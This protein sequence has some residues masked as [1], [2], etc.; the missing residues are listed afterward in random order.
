MKSFFKKL[1]IVLALFFTSS[2]INATVHTVNNG[3][4]TGGH[5]TDLQTAID[6]ANVG[7]TLYV[8]GSPNSYGA[9][10]LNKRLTLIGSGYN[11]TGTPNNFSTLVSSLTVDS[12]L[13]FS[14]ATG[15]KIIG[16]DIQNLSY[17]YISG[18]GSYFTSNLYISRCKIGSLYVFENSVLENSIITS[19][20]YLSA[21]SAIIRNNIIAS[22]SGQVSNSSGVIFDHNI[23]NG[24][25]PS[26]LSYALFSNNVFFFSGSTSN[27]SSINNCV[28]N[29]NLSSDNV[30][31]TLP[32]GTNSGSGNISTVMPSFQFNNTLTASSTSPWQNNWTLKPTSGGKNAAT[33]GTDIGIYGGN[34]PMKNL[35][36]VSNLIPQMTLMNINNSSIPLNGTLNVNF[37][38]RKQN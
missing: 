31:V 3:V 25:A 14:G 2:K 21:T 7:D 8:H 13:Y 37:K 5:F 34:Y 15:S 18:V 30:A 9:T 10:T 23:F 22:V 17:G 36:G 4:L 19:T 32:F 16:L 33:D 1:S 38:S 28:F 20:V 27:W 29:K 11:V 6:S 24:T 26:S 35:T 12:L